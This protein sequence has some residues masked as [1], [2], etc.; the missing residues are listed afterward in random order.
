M[1]WRER[2]DPVQDRDHP[3]AVGVYAWFMTQPTAEVPAA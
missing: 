3:A 1:N 2:L